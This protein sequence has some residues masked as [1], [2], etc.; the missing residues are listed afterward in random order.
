MSAQVSA[1]RRS[2][3]RPWFLSLSAQGPTLVSMEAGIGSMKAGSVKGTVVSNVEL[4]S[5]LPL[6]TH[7]LPA[8]HS[9][10]RHYNKPKQQQ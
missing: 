1:W 6:K 9:G 10:L 7:I 3:A 8:Q 2:R 4:E 5:F